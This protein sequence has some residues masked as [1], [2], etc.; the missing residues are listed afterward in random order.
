VSR[1]RRGRVAAAASFLAALAGAVVLLVVGEIVALNGAQ[2]DAWQW[3]CSGGAVVLIAVV[4]RRRS[5]QSAARDLPRAGLLAGAVAGVALL[6]V[7]LAVMSSRYSDPYDGSRLWPD[8]L[9]LLGWL[10]F[11]ATSVSFAAFSR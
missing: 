2:W 4:V 1:P 6:G 5:I 10:G 7:A 9:A 8:T 11:T 3:A